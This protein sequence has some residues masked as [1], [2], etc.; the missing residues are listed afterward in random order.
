[1]KVMALQRPCRDA[2]DVSAA[3]VRLWADSALVP[4]GRPVFP[5]PLAAGWRMRLAKA[6]RVGRLGKAIEARWA[7]RHID[8]V[9]WV[10]LF[11]PEGPFSPCQVGMMDGT[12]AVGSWLPLEGHEDDAREHQLPQAVERLSLWATLK[13]GDIIIPSM[14]ECPDQPVRL[15]THVEKSL[16]DLPCLRFNIK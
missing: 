11:E 15:D 6:W 1:M 4:G 16:Y 12:V 2:A 7:L 9:T 5:S 3:P 14:E 13:D 8:A 10:A